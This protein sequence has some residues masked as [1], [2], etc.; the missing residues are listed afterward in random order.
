[1]KYFNDIDFE[2]IDIADQI[3]EALEKDYGRSVHRIPKFKQTGR[4]TFEISCIFTDYR[5]LEADI[6]MDQVYD[7][8]TITI[9]GIYY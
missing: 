7:L 8:P 2:G 3:I 5:R 9:H 4:Y 1:M 6:K